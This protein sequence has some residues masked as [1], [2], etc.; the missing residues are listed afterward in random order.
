MPAGARNSRKGR[1]RMTKCVTNNKLP[2]TELSALTLQQFSGHAVKWYQRYAHSR[3]FAAYVRLEER[4]SQKA[5]DKGYIGLADLADIA[6][7]GGN[8]RGIKQRLLR[9]NSEREVR[10]AT[11]KAIRH[12]D[13]PADALRSMLDIKQW[14]LT[15]GSKTLRCISPENYPALD[16]KL[17]KAISKALLPTIYDG[18]IS[19]MISGYLEFL[20]IC[21]DIERQVRAPGPRLGGVWFLADIEM[22][23]FQFAWDGGRLI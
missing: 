9:N 22:A 20:N 23:L 5:S 7:W 2:M 14:G 11:Q 21:R 19:S 4:L 3:Y 18:N 12:L 17:R 1:I 8:Q 10:Q 13:N 16:Q 6:D 15:Y